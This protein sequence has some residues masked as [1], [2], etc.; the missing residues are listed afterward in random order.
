MFRRAVYALACVLALS[1]PVAAQE[2]TASIQGTVKDSS[3]AVLPGVTVEAMNLTTG[4]VAA[5]AIT[6]ANGVFRFNNLRPGKYDV[7]GRLQGFTP[8]QVKAIDLRLGQILTADIAMAVGGVTETVSVTAESPL[9]DTKQ[10]ARQTS[11]K[12]EQIALLPKGRD[13]TS[14]VTQVAG[15]N[16]ESKLGGISIDGASAGEN[17]F[18]IDGVE[19]TNLRTGLSGSNLIVDFVD[20][21]QVK[22]SGYTA[23]YGGALGGVISTVTKSGTNVFRGSAGFQIQGD[24]LEAGRAPTLRTNLSNS[25]ASEYITYPEDNET[26]IEPGFA[27]GGPIAKDRLWFF[28]AYQPAL[29]NTERVVT[30]STAQNPSAASSTTEQKNQVQYITGNITAQPSS[31]VRTRFAYNNSYSKTTD[32][33]A[34]L[35]GLDPAG[36]NYGKDSEFPNWSASGDLN[37]VPSQNFVFGVRGGYRV[38]DQHDSSVTE[39]PRYN[40]TTTNNIGYLDVPLSLQHG[41]NFTSIPTN[42]KVTRDKFDRAFVHADGTTYFNAAGSHQLK[43][44]VQFDR[45]GNDVLSGESRPRVTL[46]WNSALSGA[47]GTYGYYSVRSQA[48][49]PVQGFITEGNIHSNNIGL[50]I[51]DAWTI[52]NRLTVNVG[53]RTEREQVPTYT[54]GADI[55][56]FGVEFGF[57]DKLA[58][59]VSVAYDLKGDGRTKLFGTWGIFYDFFKLE[60]PRGS[61][62]G[63]KWLEYY[64]TLDTYAWPN[65]LASSACPPACPGTLLRTTDFRHPSFGSDAIDPDLDPMRLQEFSAGIDHELR[66]NLAVGVH[67][68]HKQ[69]DK[70][71]EDTGSL[72]AAG[73][74]IYVIANPGFNLTAL[75]FVNPNVPLPKAV[76][77]YDSVELFVDKRLSNNWSV[78]ASYLWSR[79]YGNYSGLSQSDE[80]GRTS[81]N[82]GRLWDYPMMMFDEKG[83]ASFGNLPTDRPHQL[84]GQFIYMFDFGTAVGANQYIASGLPVSRELG[85]YPPNNLPVQYHGRFS[86]GRTDTFSQTDIF[87]QHELKLGGDKRLQFSFNVLN[88]FNQQAAVSKYSTYQQTD[89]IGIP[90]EAAFYNGQLDFDDLI[91]AQHI[92]QDP[93]FLQDNG[94]QTPLSARF[95]V[96]FLF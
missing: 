65:L 28:G 33:L 6:D 19:T 47:R 83:Q 94:Y 75:A 40:W 51:Q 69:V 16:Q 90:S 8:S 81:P 56:E 23:E 66:T 39:E 41:T 91:A 24:S 34:S 38:Q 45:T 42:N 4:A 25:S 10:G 58:P 21:L 13:Y 17:R 52:N 29:T 86:D 9:I 15:A 88:L 67:Y 48:V 44:G 12:D 43:F 72:D 76:R 96:K 60:L 50:F 85:I 11:I 31:S 70:A 7:T 2:Q 1:L 22:S 84:K 78:R 14:L 62:G 71:I 74:E 46:R 36:T 77:D 82:V 63:D 95:G 5:T 18:I 37:W 26:R 64:Y 53:V 61:F 92:V 73:N 93:R 3:G 79:L 59:R 27:I 54:T 89:G 20:E 68:V 49:D 80:N 35:N 55:P 32:L 57:K 87:V 30:P